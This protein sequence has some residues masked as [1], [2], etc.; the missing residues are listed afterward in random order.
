MK[1]E[2]NL[3]RLQNTRGKHCPCKL[4]KND[5]NICPCE[6]MVLEGKCICNI[7]KLIESD[8]L[9]DNKKMVK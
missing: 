2:I 5:T 7:F 8:T 3:K 4:E 9:E 1:F 6:D